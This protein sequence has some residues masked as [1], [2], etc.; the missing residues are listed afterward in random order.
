[1]LRDCY[2]KLTAGLP[3]QISESSS[4]NFTDWLYFNP[5]LYLVLTFFCLFLRRLKI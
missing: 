4:E 5:Q 3:D 1:M 2:V